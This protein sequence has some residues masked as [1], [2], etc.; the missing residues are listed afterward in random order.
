MLPPIP[1]Q[2]TTAT[3]ESTVLKDGS[4]G[5][6]VR[7]RRSTRRIKKTNRKDGFRSRLYRARRSYRTALGCRAGSSQSWS[8]AVPA[9]GPLDSHASHFLHGSRRSPFRFETP[10]STRALLLAIVPPRSPV[11]KAFDRPSSFCAPSL[12]SPFRNEGRSPSAKLVYLYLLTPPRR[13]SSNERAEEQ[14][15]S[16]KQTY[17]FRKAEELKG[18]GR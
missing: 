14:E 9:R 18:T 7:Q 16:D 2:R 10:R 5:G 11:C 1:E 6:H 12:R 8:V 13:T 17:D 4:D 3:A 15:Q